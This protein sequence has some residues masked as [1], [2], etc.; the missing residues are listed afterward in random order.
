[1]MGLF[2]SKGPKEQDKEG[3]AKGEKDF[4]SY[5]LDSDYRKG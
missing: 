4:I 3:G 2:D 5:A 1:M